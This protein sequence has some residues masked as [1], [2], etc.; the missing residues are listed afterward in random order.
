MAAAPLVWGRFADPLPSAVWRALA[1]GGVASRPDG[2]GSWSPA[3][4]AVLTSV[5]VDA[6]LV[7]GQG[8]AIAWAR[9]GQRTLTRI[10][11]THWHKDGHTR[12]RTA[13]IRP[14]SSLTN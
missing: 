6:E 13:L 5:A 14:T 9:G 11:G 4:R 1:F 8:L 7:T 3:G 12:T 10:S 2:G